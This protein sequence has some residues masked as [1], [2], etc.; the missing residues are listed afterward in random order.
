MDDKNTTIW[1]SKKTKERLDSVGNF[2]ESYDDVL[3]RVL[4]IFEVKSPNDLV[5]KK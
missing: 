1:I 5:A 3:N 4:D 2:K